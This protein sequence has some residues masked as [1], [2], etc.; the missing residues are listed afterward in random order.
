MFDK[1]VDPR[2]YV[3]DIQPDHTSTFTGKSAGDDDILGNNKDVAEKLPD[4][5]SSLHGTGV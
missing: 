5:V 2:S 1:R 3:G 4:V